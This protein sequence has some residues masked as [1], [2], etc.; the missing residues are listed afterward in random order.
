MLEPVEIPQAEDSTYRAIFE[1]SRDGL[2]INDAETG[3]VLEANPAFCQMHGYERMAGMHPTTFIHPNSHHVFEEY[4]RAIKSGKEFHTL[5]QDLRRDGSVFDIEVLGRAFVHQGRVAML[6]V[7]RDIS[8][9]IENARLHEE[10]EQRRQE[11]EALYHADQ[12]LHRSLRLGEVLDVLVDLPVAIGRAEMVSLLMWDD[13]QRRFVVGGVRGL[14]DAML[15]ETFT[16]A[17]TRIARDVVNDIVEIEDARA[18]TRISDRLRATITREGVGAWISCPI[19]IAGHLFGSLSFGY[20]NPHVFTDRERRLL[21]A[22]AQRA[23]LAVH[24]AGLH[25]ESE[26]QRQALVALYEAD[27]ALHKSL[28]LQDVLTALVD[29]AMNLLH[30]DHVG[31]WGPDPEQPDR[32]VPF[33]SRNLSAEYVLESI[34]VRDEPGVRDFW[35]AGDSFAVEDAWNDPRVPPPQRAALEREGY[36]AFLSTKIRVG[37][38]TFGSF[39]VGHRV[40]YRFTKHE[41][42]LLASLAQRAGLAIQN[43]RLYEAAQQVAT[44]EERQRLARELHDAVTQTL[45]SSALIADV[46]PKL[47]DVDPAQARQRLTELRGLTRGALAEMRTLLVE[48]R[49]G[50]LNELPLSDLLRQL[51]EATSGRARLEVSAR[52]DGHA[53]LLPAAVHVTLYRVAQEALNNVVKHARADHAALVLSYDACRVRLRVS[54][55]GRGFSGAADGRSP[56]HFGLGIMRE[57]AGSIGAEFQLVSRPGGGTTVDITWRETEEAA[58]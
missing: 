45:F 7:V 29:A 22:L 25:E 58:P 46:L 6:G 19:R 39:T 37:Q 57:R 27:E 40:R 9:R 23:A 53:R 50:A 48:L 55:D 13:D 21:V 54:D 11:L 47:W 42:R 51:A 32:M 4:V 12:A 17:E 1:T 38:D 5:A 15:S 24:N 8:E 52:V 33:A 44:L 35:W 31:L 16:L 41:Q 2:V 20:G 28:H 26:R 18:D 56:G 49:P 43:A 10:Y 36:R 14:S 30:A 3:V 34:R